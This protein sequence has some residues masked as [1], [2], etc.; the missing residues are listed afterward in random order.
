MMTKRM[1]SSI[2]SGARAYL[3][4]VLLEGE[5]APVGAPIPFCYSYDCAFFVL[6]LQSLGV[7]IF[8]YMDGTRTPNSA[9]GSLI[10]SKAHLLIVE[11]LKTIRFRKRHDP[12]KLQV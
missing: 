6:N 3:S 4:W 1:D 2:E 10:N 8:E 12:F 7:S 5:A 9:S 11:A